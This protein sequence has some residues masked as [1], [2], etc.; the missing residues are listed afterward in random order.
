MNHPPHRA[1]KAESATDARQLAA[2]DLGSNSFHLAIAR[3][4]DDELSMLD[5]VRDQVQLAK[6]LDKRKHLTKKARER[7]LSCLAR[8]NQRLRNVPAERVRAVATSTLRSARDAAEFLAQA[9]DAL[10]HPI[11]IIAGRE[12]A[13][14]IY[15]GVAQSLADEPGPRLVVDIGGGSTELIL[16]ERF[17]ALD[18][19]SLHLGCVRM[20]NHFFAK[21]EITAARFDEAQLKAEAEIQRVERLFRESG[22]TLAVG[23]SG[24]IRT[25]ARILQANGWSN[26]GITAAG[27][28]RLRDTVLAA[29]HTSQLKLEGLK[30]ARAPVFPGGLAI[31]MALFERLDLDSMTV[32]SGAL[33]EGVMYD[34]LGRIRHEDVRERTIGSFQRRYH[35]DVPQ[36]ARVERMALA[37][38]SHMP[39]SWDLDRARD[40]RVLAWAARLHEIGLAVSWNYSHRHSSYLIAHADMAGFSKDDQELLAAVVACHRRKIDPE[41]LEHL[42]EARFERAIQLLILLRLAVL[43]HRG[44]SPEPLPPFR[45]TGEGEVVR[46]HAPKRWLAEHPLSVRDLATEHTYLKVLGVDFAL[47]E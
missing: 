32:A 16:G 46:L 8:F 4:Q 22:W 38:L 17:E 29:E 19:H 1:R 41:L 12:E 40:G 2:V 23:A 25:T 9:E 5:R 20:T 3:V 33:R 37:L 34:L 15:L 36:A 28:R 21:G 10:G 45:L 35:V 14:L 30:S 11:E 6:G 47:A 43:L 13:R 24:T 26:D 42:S 44:R 27:L 31:L 18:L 7:A 39:P